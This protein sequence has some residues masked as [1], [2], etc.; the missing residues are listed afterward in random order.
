[1]MNGD[2]E[3]KGHAVL[4]VSGFNGSTLEGDDPLNDGKTQAELPFLTM[5]K[6]LK[7]MGKQTG[8][9]GGTVIPNTQHD[10]GKRIDLQRKRNGMN[11][12]TDLVI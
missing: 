3:D 1:M 8:F 4:L 2:M 11:R 7:Q 5:V 9:N 6:S 12:V 10:G